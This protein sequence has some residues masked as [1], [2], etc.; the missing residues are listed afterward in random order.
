MMKGCTEREGVGRR[1]CIKGGRI[2]TL[3]GRES[4]GK[5]IQHKRVLKTHH[6]STVRFH[7]PLSLSLRIKTHIKYQIK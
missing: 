4:F 3:L 2:Y 1:H 5:R 7:P 6:L